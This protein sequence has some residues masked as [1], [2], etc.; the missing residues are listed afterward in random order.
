MEAFVSLFILQQ[1]SFICSF[2]VILLPDRILKFVF[3][4]NFDIKILLKSVSVFS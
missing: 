1:P 2:C 4:F 3:N